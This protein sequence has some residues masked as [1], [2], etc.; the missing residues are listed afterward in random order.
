MPIYDYQPVEREVVGMK[1]DGV[2][3]YVVLVN[4]A[5]IVP[6]WFELCRELTEASEVANRSTPWIAVLGVRRCVVTRDHN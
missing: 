5:E 3:R 2:V 6:Y 1:V 4:G